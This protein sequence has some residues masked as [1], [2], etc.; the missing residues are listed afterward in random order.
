MASTELPPKLDAMA[1]GTGMT[2]ERTTAA[3]AAESTVLTIGDI[4]VCLLGGTDC[5]NGWFTG[6][7]Q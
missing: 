6:I 4:A 3:M 1:A 7:R 2:I 5:G